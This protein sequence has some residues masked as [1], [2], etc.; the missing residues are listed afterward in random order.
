LLP[1]RGYWIKVIQEC[2]LTVGEDIPLAKGRSGG[3]NVKELISAF[4]KIYGTF[5]PPPPPFPDADEEVV[6]VPVRYELYQNYPNPFNPATTIKYSMPKDG[7]TSLVI[8]NVL[9]QKVRTLVDE[10]QKAGYY[11]VL[12]DG[13]ADGGYRVASGIYFFRLHSGD[14]YKVRKMLLIK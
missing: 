3:G 6:E 8:Y 10:K 4:N 1:N 7:K 5:P 14:Y 13:R 2:D 12:W 9:G 11:Q